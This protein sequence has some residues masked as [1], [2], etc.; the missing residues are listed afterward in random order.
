M[1]KFFSNTFLRP[2]LYNDLQRQS[3]SSSVIIEDDDEIDMLGSLTDADVVIITY[4]RLLREI[5]ILRGI[6]WG[7]V[8]LDEA[9]TIKNPKS[10][11]AQAVFSLRAIHRF[12][13]SGTPLM[14]NVDELWSLFNF[15]I[16][17]FLGD[18]E[19]FRVEYV[20]PIQKSFIVRKN[21]DGGD[22]K[23]N[24]HSV[25]ISVE[26]M[27]KLHHL[28]KQVLPFVLRRTKDSVLKEL[29]PKELID[30]YC[31]LSDIQRSMYAKF[32]H[33]L[34]LSDDRLESELL[35]IRGPAAVTNS[36]SLRLHPLKAMLHLSQLCVHHSL[37][38]AAQDEDDYGSGKLGRLANL[39]LDA[40]V[41]GHHGKINVVYI[42]PFII[43]FDVVSRVR[44]F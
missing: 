25:T 38:D 23:S 24:K 6:V 40:G 9:H 35:A 19:R 20:L 15:L 39:L 27:S 8:I 22:S 42:Y 33:G 18:F 36:S 30:I 5:S 21:V 14:N 1:T 31:P 43:Y 44:R 17:D 29:P 28:H 11:T 3:M 16:P 34:R 37:V 12:A 41:I 13:L 32:Q 7:N 10:Q 4:S 26:G 2:V